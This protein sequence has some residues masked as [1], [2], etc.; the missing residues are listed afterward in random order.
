MSPVS[1]I[2]HISPWGKFNLLLPL[3]ENN[4]T[5]HGSSVNYLMHL[6]KRAYILRLMSLVTNGPTEIK[7]TF[8]RVTVHCNGT[9]TVPW[10]FL[11]FRFWNL[12][13]SKDTTL[14]NQF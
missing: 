4:S 7:Q 12:I 8:T 9:I 2:N 11:F 14:Q 5:V 1:F 13:L 6:T 3:T 10:Q